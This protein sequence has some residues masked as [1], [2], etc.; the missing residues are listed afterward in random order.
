M[1]PWKGNATGYNGTD[2]SNSDYAG[3]GGARM[4]QSFYY[5]NNDS[6][7]GTSG[8]NDS[9][10]NG[11]WVVFMM[12]HP[13]LAHE[14]TSV[15]FGVGSQDNPN[16]GSGSSLCWSPADKGIPAISGTRHGDTASWST[17]TFNTYGGQWNQSCGDRD[18]TQNTYWTSPAWD[19]RRPFFRLRCL[20]LAVP[21]R[22]SRAGFSWRLTSVPGLG[23]PGSSS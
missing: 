8:Q 13:L 2:N 23:W 5:P 16:S 4:V 6:T 21:R 20:V 22:S 18:R 15:M 3:L 19:R 7:Y 11:T 14:Q 12:A 9:Q 17:S 10:V 1:S